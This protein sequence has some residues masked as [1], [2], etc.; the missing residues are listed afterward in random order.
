[1]NFRPGEIVSI[2]VVIGADG[3]PIL[4]DE[5]L[6]SVT[7]AVFRVGDRVSA[8]TDSYTCFGVIRIIYELQTGETFI[9]V[10]DPDGFYP[11]TS[12]PMDRVQRIAASDNP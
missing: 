2:Q 9:L 6:W 1:M 10:Q 3:R 12:F 11:M 4:P 7:K 8:R 5:K